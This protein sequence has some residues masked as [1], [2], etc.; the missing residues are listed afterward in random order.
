[1]QMHLLESTSASPLL[2]NFGSH[3]LKLCMMVLSELRATY[4][5]ADSIYRLFERAE[6]KLLESQT[7]HV[8]EDTVRRFTNTEH[9]VPLTPESSNNAQ[10]QPKATGSFSNSLV[11]PNEFLWDQYGLDAI[12]NGISFTPYDLSFS[13]D[14]SETFA[15]DLSPLG[16]SMQVDS[17]IN[18]LLSLE[19][20]N[21]QF[22]Y[23]GQP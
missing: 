14:G 3:K 4:W 8:A 7:K 16:E 21:N 6:A 18:T 23:M 2:R 15:A 17:G 12:M 22:L 11:D 13:Q 20:F 5:G 10:V 19:E 1:M 9:R